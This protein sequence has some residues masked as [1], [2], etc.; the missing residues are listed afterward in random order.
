[1]L[2]SPSALLFFISLM[3]TDICSLCNSGSV[4]F[5]PHPPHHSPTHWACSRMVDILYIFFP[6]P[7]HLFLVLQHYAIFVMCTHS[8]SLRRLFVC[9]SYFIYFFSPSF[10]LQFFY[11]P[12]LAFQ[13]L[14]L[15]F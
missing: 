9:F 10:S 6:S 13:P 11:L 12:T 4:S 3:A 7:L 15:C 8:S 1:M 2:S 5:S 14:L